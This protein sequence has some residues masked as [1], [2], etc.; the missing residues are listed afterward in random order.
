M[1]RKM[2]LATLIAVFASV[3]AFAA[4]INGRWK[5]SFETP[6]GTQNYTYEFK[7][8]GNSVTGKAVNDRGETQIGSVVATIL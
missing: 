7:V 1:I 3:T 4:D 8:E 6:M 2:F 5:A